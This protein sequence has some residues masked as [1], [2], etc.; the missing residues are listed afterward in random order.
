MGYKPKQHRCPTCGHIIHESQADA[1]GKEEKPKH[2]QVLGR[3]KKVSDKALLIASGG[4]E[5]W[6]PRSQVQDGITLK[7]GDVDPHV[8]AWFVKR[9]ALMP[10]S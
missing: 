4:K 9:E 1:L 8:V 5:V 7:E 3:I 10:R 2:V 6:V